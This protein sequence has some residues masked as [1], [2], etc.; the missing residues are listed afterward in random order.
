MLYMTLVLVCRNNVS[1][2]AGPCVHRQGSGFSRLGCMLSQ[3]CQ[4]G[5]ILCRF[6]TS[7]LVDLSSCKSMVVQLDF[8]PPTI[9]ESWAVIL[10]NKPLANQIPNR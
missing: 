10:F 3:P 1:P 8:P 5:A 9:K 2:I 4:S 7:S 6:K